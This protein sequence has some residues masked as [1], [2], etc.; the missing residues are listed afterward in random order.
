M[1]LTVD[2]K[3]EDSVERAR[4]ESSGGVVAQQEY[5]PGEFEGPFRVF[6]RGTSAPGLA[7]SRSLGDLEAERVGVVPD[8]DGYSVRLQRGD[9][10]LLIASDGLWEVGGARRHSPLSIAQARFGHW[11]FTNQS[12]A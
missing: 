8:A 9:Q 5:D 2:H 7:M 10:L 12:C 4:I 3:P 6:R 11:P 1:E